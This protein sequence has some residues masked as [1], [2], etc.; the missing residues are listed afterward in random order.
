MFVDVDRNQKYGIDIVWEFLINTY[1]I[2]TPLQYLNN[3]P[4]EIHS[5]EPINWIIWLIG[6]DADDNKPKH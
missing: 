3:L 5:H 2:F 1:L 4:S 6:V